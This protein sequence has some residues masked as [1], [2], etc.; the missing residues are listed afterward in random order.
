MVQSESCP[1]DPPL[2]HAEALTWQA[3]GGDFTL[4]IPSLTLHKRTCLGVIGPSG[5]GKSTLL[6]L[7]SLALLPTKVRCLS[8][9]E[10]QLALY[11]SPGSHTTNRKRKRLFTTLRAEHVGFIPQTGGLL[12][13]LTARENIALALNVLETPP[14]GQG[15]GHIDMLAERLGIISCL[16]K[17][18]SQLSVGQRQRVAIAR[19]LIHTPPILLADE[20]TAPLHPSQA[21]I[22]LDLLRNYAETQ[23]AGVIVVSHDIDA[24]QKA[25]FSL[26]QA[27]MKGNKTIIHN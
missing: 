8:L 15:A 3:P 21:A 13:F 10:R 4:E 1:A 18:P 25:E 14:S 6:G 23:N 2:L 7:L 12:P 16:E 20:P 11:L 27:Q 19:A 9:L 5:C 26:V 22:V 17:L 24:L